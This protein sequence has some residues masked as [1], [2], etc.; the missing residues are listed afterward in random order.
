M[1]VL[2]PTDAF[3]YPTP[4]AFCG[5]STTCNLRSDILGLFTLGRGTLDD[6]IARPDGACGGTRAALGLEPAI[7][8]VRITRILVS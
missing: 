8:E 6:P 5:Q 3:K 7:I 1:T 4:S 2:S